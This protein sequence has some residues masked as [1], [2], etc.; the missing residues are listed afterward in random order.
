MD[1]VVVLAQEP[2]ARSVWPSL[3]LLS[4]PQHERWRF[5]VCASVM[6]WKRVTRCQRVHGHHSDLS[7]PHPLSIGARLGHH[8]SFVICLY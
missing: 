1:Y 5:A 2:P 7:S 8:M 3:T 6:V 4:S